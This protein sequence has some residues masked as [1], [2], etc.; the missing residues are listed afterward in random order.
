VVTN[1]FVSAS[2]TKKSEQSN[3]CAC[4]LPSLDDYRDLFSKYITI[5]NPERVL[6]DLGLSIGYHNYLRGAGPLLIP[7]STYSSKSHILRIGTTE[8]KQYDPL[9]AAVGTYQIVEE[10]RTQ[11]FNIVPYAPEIIPAEENF[12]SCFPELQG[13]FSTAN[14]TSP[15]N[16]ST[17][18]KVNPV[19]QWIENIISIEQA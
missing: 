16:S 7:D 6:L 19:R 4:L 1:R 14:Y 17:T 9:S 13:L 12:I 10:E 3:I 2:G 11:R 18:P 8:V 5:R 15:I